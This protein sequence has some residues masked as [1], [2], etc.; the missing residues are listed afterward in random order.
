M[1]NQ[2][3]G[4]LSQVIESLRKIEKEQ[5]QN[6]E[7]AAEL[8]AG[9]IEKDQLIHVYGGGGHTTLVMGE[10]FFRAGGLANINPIMETGLSVFNQAL[11]YLELE[12]TVN[13]G[14]S[15]V[16]YYRIREGEVLIIF[17]NIGINAAT[18]DAAMEAKKCGAKIIAVSS[19]FWQNEMPA[20]HFI[21]H[22]SKKNLFDFADVCI[23][24]YNPV[25]DAVIKVN[26]FDTPIAPISNITDFYIAHRLEIATIKKCVEKNIVPPVWSSANAPGGDEINAKYVEK[27]LPRVKCL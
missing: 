7:K 13:Y 6:I 23:D 2:D 25:G 16:K 21:R 26:G 27:Y 11:K 4:Y 10:M 8:L 24:D 20:E 19:S 12:R 3:L 17:H 14:S 22:P 9:A 15:I 5:S 18:I 1:E